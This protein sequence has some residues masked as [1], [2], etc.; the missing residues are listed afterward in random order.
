MCDY[1]LLFCFFIFYEVMRPSLP[2]SLD[3]FG[4]KLD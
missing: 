3:R 4:Y 2:F 1:L